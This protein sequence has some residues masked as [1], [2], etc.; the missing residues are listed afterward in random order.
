M[1]LAAARR[2]ICPG[3]RGGAMMERGSREFSE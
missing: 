1:G 3:V 2:N